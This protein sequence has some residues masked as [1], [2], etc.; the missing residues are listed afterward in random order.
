MGRRGNGEG[1]IYQRKS[2]GK[3]VCSITLE[4]G[5]RKVLY[6]NTRK[7]VQEKLKVVLREQQQGKVIV[8][9]QQTVKQF[10]DDWLENTHR[11]NVRPRSYERYEELIRLH[12]VPSLGK[13]QLQK[14]AP[15]HLRKLYTD[16][17]KEGLSPKTV[18]SIH[19]LL[20]TALDVAV[21]WDLVAQNVT[22]KVSPPRKV[23]HEIKPLSPEQIHRLLDAAQGHP[24]EALLI[25]ALST[26]MRRGELLGLKWQDIDFINGTLQVRRILNR[27]PTKM[28]KEVGQSFVDA[29]P[30][31]E[32]SRRQIVLASFAIEALKQHRARQAEMKKEAGTD[33]QEHDYVFSN[34][35]GNYLHPGNNVLVPFKRLLK[36]AG[37]PDVRFHD[38]RHSA[39]TML[40]S[41]GVHPKVVQELL[42][43]SEIGMTLNIYSHV[44]PTMQRDAISMLNAILEDHEDKA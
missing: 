38:L 1:S 30:K 13:I 27:V 39:A 32:K 37:L 23:H 4:N 22:E 42:G 9:P 34:A 41:K 29:E 3:W 36:K 16:K 8:A 18:T 15:Q 12:I 21:K 20:H 44:L 25:L 35:T 31:T 2:D 43:H 11:Q 33:W 14:L 5:K 26:G 40:L 19:N 24:L 7:E 6:G 17:L 10:L 28:V